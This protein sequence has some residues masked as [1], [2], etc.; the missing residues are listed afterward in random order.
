MNPKEF[1]S[2]LEAINGVLN[3]PQQIIFEST[4]VE[5]VAEAQS[6]PPKS[7]AIWSRKHNGF[8]SPKDF[9]KDIKDTHDKMRKK[10]TKKE[11]VELSPEQIEQLEEHLTVQFLES[12]FGGELNEDTEDDDITNAIVE[13]NA[14]CRAV[15]S[16][17]G[18]TEGI[19][20]GLAGGVL[21]SALGPLGAIGGAYLGHKIQQ[22]G[23]KNKKQP[24]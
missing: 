20:G 12:Y 14:T 2:H 23:N 19:A 11:S 22:S 18:V 17:F 10:S 6:T 24:E 16:Y 4:E 9:K 3:T 15:N 21:G 5:E 13:L 8:V 1:K 7:D